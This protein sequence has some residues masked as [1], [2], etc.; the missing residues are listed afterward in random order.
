MNWIIV[1][2]IIAFFPT[3]SHASST[4]IKVKKVKG[5]MALVQ[6]QGEV[7]EGENY[8][9]I[10]SDQSEAN[11]KSGPREHRLGLNFNFNSLKNKTATVD[12]NPSELTITGDYG[13]NFGQHEVGPVFGYSSVN[14]GFGGA[15]T[16]LTLGLF[17]DY[18]FTENK[19]PTIYLFGA[20]IRATYSNIT[21]AAGATG[22]YTSSVF[23][24][25]FWK[26]W[27]FT[28]STAIRF[29][30]GFYAE[31]ARIATAT[32]SSSTGFKSTGALLF[33]Y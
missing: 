19:E 3:L 15:T 22:L 20:S 7:T 33:Y 31:N 16:Y 17:Y 13:W 6:F 14:S 23:P 27:A 32:D 18:N 24:S 5:H 9:L 12:S 10:G 4:R 30:L 2:I 28:Q 21:S 26:W 29:D 8:M 11:L 25:I 1:V